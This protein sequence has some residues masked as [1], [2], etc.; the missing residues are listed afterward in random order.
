QRHV[1]ITRDA[2]A[3]LDGELFLIQA[4]SVPMKAANEAIAAANVRVDDDQLHS[5]LHFDG[6]NFVAGQGRLL[7][8]KQLVIASLQQDD[9]QGARQSLGEA[10]HSIQDFY[11]HSNWT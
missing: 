3:A 7:G 8:L 5:A 2:L 1:Q 4:P 10:L 6:E 9:A 11:A